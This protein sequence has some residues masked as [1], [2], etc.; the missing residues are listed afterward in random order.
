MLEQRRL[1]L[2]LP[3][4]PPI[5]VSVLGKKTQFPVRGILLEHI[6]DYLDNTRRAALAGSP[7]LRAGIILGEA[8]F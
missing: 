3:D 8:L 1:Q 4:H 2:M 6:G 7:R 5:H